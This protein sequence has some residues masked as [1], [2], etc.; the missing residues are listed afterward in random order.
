METLINLAQTFGFAAATAAGLGWVLWWMMGQHR[1]ERLEWREVVERQ[2]T[3]CATL[4]RETNA[5]MNGLT[6]VV[7]RL[8]DRERRHNGDV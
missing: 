1:A 3:E 8:A 4:Q 5:A 6:L 7:E 2:H